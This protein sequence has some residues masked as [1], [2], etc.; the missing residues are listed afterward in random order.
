MFQLSKN[1]WELYRCKKLV[2][3]LAGK[4]V[5]QKLPKPISFPPSVMADMAVSLLRCFH[6]QERVEKKLLVFITF[7][8]LR[9]IFRIIVWL[10]IKWSM[11]SLYSLKY[12]NYFYFPDSILTWSWH[13]GDL[14]NGIFWLCGWASASTLNSQVQLVCL[15][16]LCSLQTNNASPTFL[17]D[18]LFANLWRFFFGPFATWFFVS[19]L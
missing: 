13:H 2:R 1:T 19:K 14:M 4:W 3:L 6:W 15:F 5:S 12:V 7:C 9:W 16:D 11:V 10:I 18:Y 17:L 8:P